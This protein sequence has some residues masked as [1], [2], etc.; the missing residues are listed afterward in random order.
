MELVKHSEY[1]RF[2]ETYEKALTSERVGEE[3]RR[4]IMCSTN[5]C[6]VLRNWIA[7]KSIEE[8]EEGDFNLVRLTER[9]LRHPYQRQEEADNLG[10]S[11]K[12]PDWEKGLKVSCSS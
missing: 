5:P 4:S 12:P 11:E 3:E 7:Q 2:L 6:Y 1:K 8:A 9:I 10:F